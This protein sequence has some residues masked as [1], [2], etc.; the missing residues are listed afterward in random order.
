VKAG[1]K[2]GSYRALNL[3]T[4]EKRGR[5]GGGGAHWTVYR[6]PG[7]D[8]GANGLGGRVGKTPTTEPTE[9]RKVRLK[10]DRGERGNTGGGLTQVGGGGTQKDGGT[11]GGERHTLLTC[12]QEMG[13]RR[14]EKRNETLRR[15]GGASPVQPRRRQKREKPGLQNKEKKEGPAADGEPEHAKVKKRERAHLL[16]RASKCTSVGEVRAG[17]LEAMTSSG[18]STKKRQ[19]SAALEEPLNPRPR[20]EKARK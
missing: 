6:N 18:Q 12:A 3:S 5:N 4:R 9:Q 1:C 17:N 11:T 7:W 15:D 16:L 14:T 2:R 20:G 19:R 8:T 13:L 10:N